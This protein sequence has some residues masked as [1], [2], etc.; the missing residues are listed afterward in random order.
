MSTAKILDGFRLSSCF[1]NKHITKTNTCLSLFSI[2]RSDISPNYKNPTY[3]LGETE[4]QMSWNGGL[5]HRFLLDAHPQMRKSKLY[6][7]HVERPWALKLDEKSTLQ[8]CFTGPL[9]RPALTVPHSIFISDTVFLL[10][11]QMPL[12]CCLPN[13]AAT[14][15]PPAHSWPHAD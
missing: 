5:C 13:S 6:P 3:H 4:G 14:A 7:C 11:F 8:F 10:Y 2:N 15:V 9:F 1:G 12:Y